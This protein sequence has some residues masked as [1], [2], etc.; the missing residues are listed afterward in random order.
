MVVLN[1]G[2][3]KTDAKV[4]KQCVMDESDPL[5]REYG[6]YHTGIDLE[7][8]EVYSQFDGLVV[9]VGSS[10]GLYSIFIQTGSSICIAY[11]NIKL[12]QVRINSR[13]TAG[14]KIGTVDKFVTV[15][16]LTRQGSLWPCTVGADRWYVHPTDAVLYAGYVAVNSLIQFSSMNIIESDGG[17]AQYEKPSSGSLNSYQKL[18]TGV[19]IGDSKFAAMHSSIGSDP[20]I[21]L[22]SSTDVLSIL[23]R[24][25]LQKDIP[26][27]SAILVS[28]S[29]SDIQ[30]SNYKDIADSISRIASANKGN[31]IDVYYVAYGPVNN[32][33]DNFKIQEFNKSVAQRLS[34]N[35]GYI[36]MFSAVSVSFEMDSHGRYSD[37]TNHIIYS[38]ITSAAGVKS[39]IVASDNDTFTPYIVTVSRSTSDSFSYA[40]L[41]QN[42]V[43]GVILEAGYMFDEIHIKQQ[44]FENPRLRYQMT[45]VQNCGLP[46]GFYMIGR[47]RTVAEA[48]DEMYWFS[49]PIRRYPPSLG[50]WIQLD[51]SGTKSENNKIIDEYYKCLYRLGFRNKMGFI[52]D[53]GHLKKID[54]DKYQDFWY[55]WL[56]QHVKDLSEL[57]NAETPEFFDL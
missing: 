55:L 22:V 20:N 48:K 30:T 2:I 52:A 51:L 57:E 50:V 24:S 17:D 8:K 21:W 4:L 23:K 39:T 47:A 53:R 43:S 29:I 1:C 13:V 14:T 12:V 11:S 35:V 36:D 16:L 26:R 27:N 49:F 28:A 3:T 25:D 37:A 38:L 15:K 19:F 7:C 42:Q 33:E 54:W 34:E 31:N 41:K 32:T 44:H 5:F 56:I 10:N 40:D 45:N 46:H 9:W 6:G 18:K